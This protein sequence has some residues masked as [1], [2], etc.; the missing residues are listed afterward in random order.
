M[1]S[2]L[3][4][5]FRYKL[6]IS[7]VAIF[8]L[9]FSGATFFI[10]RAI[11]H[12]ILIELHDSQVHQA[13][14]FGEVLGPLVSK[15]RDPKN[16]ERVMRLGVLSGMR[17][18]AMDAKGEVVADSDK[19]WE[20]LH[21]VENHALRPEVR[22]AL[23]GKEGKSRRYSTTVNK[24][25]L[26]VALPILNGTSIEGVMRVAWPLTHVEEVIRAA[27]HP[28]GVSFVMGVGIV[29]IWGIWLGG[30]LT[31]RIRT[32]TDT[33]QRFTQGDLSQ[34]AL[35][36]S[37]D[38]FG[39]LAKTMNQMASALTGRLRDMESEQKKL[40]AII[41]SMSEGVLAV[42]ISK[43]ILMMNPAAE[44]LFKIERSR[45]EGRTLIEAARNSEIDEM[46]TR[47]LE[48]QGAHS[49]E[50]EWV[51]AG[52]QILKIQAVGISREE[53]QVAGVMV[54]ADLT[55]LRR[56]ERNRKE[57]LANVSHELR[58][59]LTSLQGIIETIQ[60]DKQMSGEQREKFLKIMEE[61]TSRLRRLVEDLMELSRIESRAVSFQPEWLDMKEETERVLAL[62][63]TRILENRIQIDN[64]V[65]VSGPLKM[66]ADR[67]RMHQILVNLIDN[68]A[69]FNRE[70]GVIRLQ[71]GVTHQSA[72]ISVADS[73]PGIPPESLERVFER[74]YR[75]DK[76]RSRELGGSGLGLAITKHLV[77][78]QG[79]NIFCQS[80]LGQG[81]TFTFH[82]PVKPSGIASY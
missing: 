74:F 16:Q 1:F 54:L 68:A 52:G 46:M 66:F 45:A 27:Q 24:Q 79:G 64:Q 58:T 78:A 80:E 81:S 26:Y 4:Q 53:G 2:L 50:I 17:I 19:T 70:G 40:S 31:R 33:A 59:P 15:G 5:N 3:K 22:A 35:L 7:Y 21:Q 38:D 8:F 77:E 47:A 37:Q 65:G 42:D 48:D 62:L 71:G 41:S 55:D 36:D 14:L 25:M 11:E 76:A 18:T 29:I 23:N 34:R 28:I 75:V 43:N 44:R 49:M 30:S 12:Q 82:L 13:K 72:W 9:V 67:D 57:F 56:L 32:L 6:T 69:K 39:I 51:Q 10:L 20:T 63:K 73:G 60:D 61:D